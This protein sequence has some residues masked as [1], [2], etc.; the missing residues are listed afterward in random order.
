MR[1]GWLIYV[2]RYVQPIKCCFKDIKFTMNYMYTFNIDLKT[3][4]QKAAILCL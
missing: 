2:C 1:H 4:L 3:K